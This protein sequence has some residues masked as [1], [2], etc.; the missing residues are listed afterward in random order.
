MNKKRTITVD[1]HRK[2]HQKVVT[3]LQALHFKFE[4]Q[5]KRRLTNLN[6]ERAKKLFSQEEFKQSEELF[7]ETFD[8]AA[9]GI[10]H[11]GLDGKWLRVNQKFCEIAGY[12]EK[13][14]LTLSFLDITHPDDHQLDL[15]LIKEL[16]QGK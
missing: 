5:L 13:E 10:A 4:K 9:V 8:H 3:K 12:S 11:V 7:K 2:E 16:S 14:L 1:K 6:T 15:K